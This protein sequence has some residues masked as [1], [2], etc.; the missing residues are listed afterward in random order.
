MD[1]E[2]MRAM[3]YR[4]ENGFLPDEQY[5]PTAEDDPF[6]TEQEEVRAMV[7]ER[8]AATNAERRDERLRTENSALRALLAQHGVT[9]PDDG[10]PRYYVADGGNVTDW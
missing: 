9:G 6:D 1:H 8:Y 4:E 5:V 7:A 3:Q 2:E 10:D